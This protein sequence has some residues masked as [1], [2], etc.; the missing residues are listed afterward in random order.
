MLAARNM[1]LRGSRKSCAFQTLAP[2]AKVPVRDTHPQHP[3]NLI[4]NHQRRIQYPFRERGASQFRRVPRLLGR[5]DSQYQ[6]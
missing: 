3:S 4:R 6:Y 1:P 5:T 2:V